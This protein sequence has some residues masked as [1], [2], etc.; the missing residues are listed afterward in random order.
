VP[1]YPLELP[2]AE[3]EDTAGY[4]LEQE[5]GHLLPVDRLATLMARV[6]VD[7]D[8]AAFAYPSEPVGPLYD[9]I[10]A[11]RLAHRLGWSVAR[12]GVGWRRVV[13]SPGPRSI[14]ELPT[15][16]VLVDIGVTV[17]C[18]GGGRHPGTG[19]PARAPTRRRGRR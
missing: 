6:V 2:D 13:A 15:L 9:G 12:P 10:G 1:A 14:V 5:L 7:P 4:L 18:P 3:G 8:D 19:D 17:I 11:E 16:R